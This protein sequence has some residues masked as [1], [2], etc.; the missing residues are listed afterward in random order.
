M[1]IYL[2]RNDLRIKNICVKKSKIPEKIKIT[3]LTSFSRGRGGTPLKSANKQT[4]HIKIKSR[5]TMAEALLIV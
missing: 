5:T 3:S 2:F 4:P 1:I